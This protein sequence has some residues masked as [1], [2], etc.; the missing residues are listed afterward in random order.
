MNV[1]CACRR[2]DGAARFMF[3]FSGNGQSV[4]GVRATREDV[5]TLRTVDNTRSCTLRTTSNT[6]GDP[7]D[8]LI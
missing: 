7:L 8:K 6:N 1:G 4:N 2:N 5:K 3:L